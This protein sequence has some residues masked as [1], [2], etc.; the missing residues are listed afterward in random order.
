MK[1]MGQELI[2]KNA[3]ITGGNSGMGRA[4]AEEFIRQ[5]A[6]VAIVGRDPKTLREAGEALGKAAVVIQADVSSLEDLSRAAA[7]IRET[8]GKVDIVF[9]NAGIAKFQSLAQ[10]SEAIFDQTFDIN[11][12][13]AFFTV[14]KLLPFL[15]EAA[16]VILNT[17]FL[18][19]K[20]WPN[21]AAY[22]ASKA[23]VRS[24]V[25]SMAAELAPRGVR[26]NA[27][28]PGPIETPIY[29]R[30][31]MSAE[32]VQGLAGFVL[33]QTPLKRFGKPEEVARLAL[34]LASSDSSFLTG[35]EI[36]IDG[37]IGQV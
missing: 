27:I 37:G 16:S 20:G 26:V 13:G 34:F 12:K 25:R 2:G 36:S 18:K 32:E 8:L 24:L 1:L 22:A 17:T 15:N 4:T 10:T 6:R 21:T 33:Q 7:R 28:S 3:V 14:Q 19:D 11:V 30:L 31:G 35:T 23:A 29:G 5:G 9:A